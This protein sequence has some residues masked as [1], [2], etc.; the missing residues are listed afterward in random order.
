MTPVFSAPSPLAKSQTTT[1]SMNNIAI[2]DSDI[3]RLGSDTAKMVGTTTEKIIQKMGVGKFEELGKILVDVQNEVYKLD[4]TSVQKSGISGWIQRNFGN[5]K[6]ELTIHM[7]NADKVFTDLSTKIS[8][9]ITVQTEWI[10]DLEKLY[11][12]N[13]QRY[14]SIVAVIAEGEK[15]KASIE[16]SLNNWPA[17]DPADPDAPMKAQAKRDVESS[18]KRL[19][20]KLDSFLR[21]KTVVE[22]NAPKIRQQ[23]DTSRTT[24]M[25]L[26]DVIEQTIPMVKSEFALF[27]QSLDAQKSIEIVNNAKA[28]A[29][30]TLIKSADSAKTAAVE[31]AKT[32]NSSTI[33]TET[34]MHIKNRMLETVSEVK[35]IDSDAQ[36]IRIQ[37]KLA[38]EQSQKDYLTAITQTN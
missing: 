19:N 36:Q 12:E 38:I 3:E 28:L 25:T 30:T 13:F 18:L 22:S 1:V 37:D 11:E 33:S 6:R 34:L 15:W 32:L 5:I 10:K 7:S 14:N 2:K 31:A 27:M 4:P 9:H 26:K 20:I 23:Q 21:F 35:K 24:V 16:D 29:N 8:N 17:I